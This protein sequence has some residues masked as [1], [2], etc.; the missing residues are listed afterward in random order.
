MNGPVRKEFCAIWGL[1]FDDVIYANPVW[2]QANHGIIPKE[3]D[4]DI[5]IG[6]RVHQQDASFQNVVPPNT[7]MVGVPSA[8]VRYVAPN[9]VLPYPSQSAIFADPYAPQILPVT[10]HVVPQAS[11]TAPRYTTE[12]AP[13]SAPPDIDPPPYSEIV[14]NKS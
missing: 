3:R 1:P 6:T 12:E 10:Y 8:G 14:S 4:F 11:P 9:S 13:P 5:W 7:Q 2:Q